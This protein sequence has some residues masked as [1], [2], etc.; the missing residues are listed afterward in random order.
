MPGKPKA[1]GRHIALA[2]QLAGEIG[3]GRYRVGARFPSEQEL[4]ERFDLGRHTIREALKILTEQGMLGRRRKTGSVVLARKPVAQYVH[5]LRDMSG[6]FD[7]AH[8]TTLAVREEEIVSN[9]EGMPVEKPAIKRWCKIAGV[10]S[11]RRDGEPL[12]WSEVMVPERF[13]PDPEALSAGD[14]A[15]YEIIL[16]QYGLKLDYVEQEVSA[17]VLPAKLATLLGAKSDKAALLVRRRYVAEGNGTFEVS[18]NLYPS[19]RY[20]MKSVIRKRL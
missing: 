18:L 20:S 13:C 5:S 19:R 14:Q 4:Q 16:A 3:S 15:I 9:F 17:A 8:S 12:C 2:K 1:A 6:L 10:R 7:F 11:T